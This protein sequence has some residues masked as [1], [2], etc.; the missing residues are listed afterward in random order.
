MDIQ[1]KSWNSS[2]YLLQA[3]F[4]YSQNTVLQKETESF[5]FSKYFLF[6]LRL[7]IADLP[8]SMPRIFCL[9]TS[10]NQLHAMIQLL[11]IKD[12]LI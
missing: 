12:W 1:A 2:Q 3:Q 11:F 9:P 5:I 10:P 4:Q 8:S 6:F 7:L